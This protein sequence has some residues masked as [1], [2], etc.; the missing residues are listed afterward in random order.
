MKKSLSLLCS[1]V[2]VFALVTCGGG[3]SKSE[4]DTG[5]NIYV[6]GSYGS[7]YNPDNPYDDDYHPIIWKNGEAQTFSNGNSYG[8]ATS[9]FVTGDAWYAAGQLGDQATLWKNGTEQTLNKNNYDSCWANS[10]FVSNQ[11]VYVVGDIHNDSGYAGILWKNG[12]PQNIPDSSSL[13]SVFVSGNDVYVGG[14]IKYMVDHSSDMGAVGIWKNGTIFST[15]GSFGN[16]SR[17]HSIYVS[18]N[19]VYAAGE[20]GGSGS[21]WARLWKN[22]VRQALDI[23]RGTAATSVAVSGNDVYVA[24]YGIPY[25]KLWKN[26]VLQKL[27]LD[28]GSGSDGSIISVFVFG[29]D[30]YVA[31]TEYKNYKGT[32]TVWKNGKV[33]QR[34]KH[35]DYATE[36][37]SIFVK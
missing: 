32:A 2:L 9:V 20:E 27:D 23:T 6:V 22:G 35:G 1:N 7:P 37:C 10:V 30:V 3:G 21:G 5:P 29:N 26:G 17:I 15:I 24:G 36:A 14:E 8:Y 33:H 13:E 19:D 31:G 4:E 28:A 16:L 11:D 12:T 25:A 34:L 18:G